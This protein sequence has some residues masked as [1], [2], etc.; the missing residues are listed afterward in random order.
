VEVG[1]QG[2]AEMLQ[3]VAENLITNAIQA[4]GGS[5]TLTV[6]VERH[7]GGRDDRPRVE[8]RVGDTGVGMGEAFVRDRLFR[9][10]A[11]TKRKGLGLGLYQCRRIVEAHGG[12][13]LVES[14]KGEG[15]M[16]RIL[17]P[18]LVEGGVAVTPARAA[19]LVVR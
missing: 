4:M 14:K 5:G 8:L 6:S 9:P 19:P 1:V 18:G 3:R 13:I 7:P 17:L 10:F 2:D 16:F 11:T 15:T 12:E